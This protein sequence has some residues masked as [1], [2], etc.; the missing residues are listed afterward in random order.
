MPDEEKKFKLNFY[1]RTSLWRLK[2]FYEGLK[3]LHFLYF[4]TTFRSARDGKG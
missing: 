4:N 2:R 3:G 1:F